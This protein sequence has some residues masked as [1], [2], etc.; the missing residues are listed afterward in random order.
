MTKSC[1]NLGEKELD[2]ATIQ[3]IIKNKPQIALS[4][5]AI[6]RIQKCREYLDKKL[7]NSD[8]AFY[9]INT[10]FGYLQN[11]RIEQDQIE[12]LQHNLLLSHACGLGDLIPQEI[13][14][15]MLFLKIQ[16]L[17]YGNS[18]INLITINRLV[19]LYNHNILPVIF[20]QGS[21]GASGDLAPLSHLALPLIGEGEVYEDGVR[22]SFTSV[23]QKLGWKPLSLKSKE[24]LALING[25]QFMSSYAV[26]CLHRTNQILNMTQLIAAMSFDAFDCVSFP[27]HEKIHAIRNQT[28]QIKVAEKLRNILTGS[29][30]LNQKKSQVQDPY[31]FRCIPQVVGAS[32]DAVEYV[33][34]IFMKEV[35]G[36]TDNPN[37][38]PDDDLILSG[39][40]F[41]GQPLAISL[42]FLSIA[43]SEIGSISERRT[44]Q[45]ISGQRNLPLFLISKP[46]LN[47]GFMIPQYTAA[48][49]VS[50]NKQLCTPSS[51]DSI[52]SSNNQEDHVSMGANAA[53]KC[54]KI[55]ENVEKVL[56]IELLTAAQALDFRRP[57]KSSDSIE[58]LHA[59][60][61]EVVSF[62]TEDRLLHKDLISSIEFFKKYSI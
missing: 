2:F 29:E 52:P 34:S 16:S 50:E 1:I 19:D 23:Q 60:Y 59:R 4:N 35:N 9:G 11:V 49:I 36:V 26:Y 7:E 6:E 55:I 62:N 31:S 33:S 5:S 27:L 45:L 24:G 53:V 21:L 3:S 20:T 38:F 12:K 13:V 30:I 10:G 48:G 17:V 42:D 22:M 39:G 32:L 46:G 28:G 8:E 37:I 44:Y 61:R 47:S 15:L 56:S 25:T 40:N 14:R 18:G 58:N 41:H 51:I 54:L 57:Q 43:V